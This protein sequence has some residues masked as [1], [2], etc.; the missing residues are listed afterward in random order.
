MTGLN[1]CRLSV[2]VASKGAPVAAGDL[3]AA[4]QIYE[5]EQAK[6]PSDAAQ[7]L[8]D[9]YAIL[10]Q[11]RSPKTGISSLRPERE[12]SARKILAAYAESRLDHD[13]IADVLTS[14]IKSM[15][16]AETFLS[17]TLWRGHLRMMQKSEEI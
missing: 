1:I 9:L 11:T 14:L 15:K 13:R 5:R 17:V 8:G 12:N 7:A 2:G 16:H 10:G 3:Q 6:N 4:V